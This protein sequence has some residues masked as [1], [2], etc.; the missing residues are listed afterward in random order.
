[1]IQRLTI[2]L[3]LG[4]ALLVTAAPEEQVDLG[5]VNRIRDEGFGN[6]KVM[7]TLFQLTDWLVEGTD[8]RWRWP[9]DDARLPL[10]YSLKAYRPSS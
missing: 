4:G 9:S 5:M 6:S 1:M 10:M 2:S 3:V 8:G 7:D